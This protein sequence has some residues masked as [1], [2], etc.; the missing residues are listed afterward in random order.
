MEGTGDSYSEIMQRLQSSLAASSFPKTNANSLTLP[1]ASSHSLS[2]SQATLSQSQ[3]LFQSQSHSLSQAPGSFSKASP[4]LH[5]QSKPQAHPSRSLSQGM[6]QTHPAPHTPSH[7]RSLSQP[8]I[9]SHMPPL[10]S[11]TPPVHSHSQHS[12]HSVTQPG[13][14]SPHSSITLP[15]ISPRFPSASPVAPPT[16]HTRSLSQPSVLN[17]P[18]SGGHL[19]PP[20]MGHLPPPNSMS[21]SLF[22]GFNNLAPNYSVKKEPSPSLSDSSARTTV[23]L[24]VTMEESS[25]CPPVV[26]GPSSSNPLSPPL[27]PFHSV[28]QRYS[29][30]V[31]QMPDSPPRRRGHRRAHSEIAFR[32]GSA[33]EKELRIESRDFERD[34]VKESDLERELNSG[35]ADLDEDMDR[36]TGWG[37]DRLRDRDGDRDGD[38]EG[39]EDLFSMYIDMEKINSFSN[40]GGGDGAESDRERPVSRVDTGKDRLK[41]VAENERQPA[42]KE[43]ENQRVRSGDLENGDKERARESWMK[44]ASENDRGDNKS[45][46]TTDLEK[47]GTSRME[48][49]RTAEKEREKNDQEMSKSSERETWSRKEEEEEKEASS[50]CVENEGGKDRSDTELEKGKFDKSPSAGPSHHSRSVSMDG[51]LSN[52]QGYKAGDGGHQSSFSEDRRNRPTRHH[53]S[54][55]MDG[56]TSLKMEFGQGEF[57]GIELK[58]AMANDKLADLALVDPKRAKRILANRQSAARS[59]ERKMRYISELERK[60]QTLQT[61]ATTLSAQLTMLQRD[62]SGLTTE[63]SELKLRLSAME[64]Q[65]QLRDALNDA[66]RE[67]VQRLKLATGQLSNGQGMTLSQQIAVNPQLYQLHQQLQQQVQSQGSHQHQPV[68][69]NAHSDFLQ[70]SAFGALQGLAGAFLKTEGNGIAVNQGSSTSF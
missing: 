63:N 6:S 16:H 30:D 44:T 62:S 45:A 29:S 70:R 7:S 5:S 69:Q 35:R 68:Q 60:V 61:E 27:N 67:E 3:S 43:D 23:S 38:G 64:Q 21:H 22:A 13:S 4:F 65:A 40:S 66:L 57:E 58:K 37:R 54:M 12:P 42:E 11:Q 51:F 15:Q 20:S 25:P 8:T 52:L 34:S 31:S 26:S 10:Q 56:S 17:Q 41:T 46:S 9:R 49:V 55:S 53:H 24:D 1:Q 32:P 48:D 36:A 50:M 19:S 59:K 18:S 47:S 14:Q 39:A 28:S 33:F 2:N